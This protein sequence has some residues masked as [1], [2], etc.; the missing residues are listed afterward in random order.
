MIF[1]MF[2]NFNYKE[3]INIDNEGLYINLDNEYLIFLVAFKLYNKIHVV[4]IPINFIYYFNIKDK[5]NNNLF[6]PLIIKIN[7]IEW[8]MHNENIIKA[9]NKIKE[10]INL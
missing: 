9:N 4:S 5:I 10:L 3:N 6:Y 7:S 1:F 2:N 8:I